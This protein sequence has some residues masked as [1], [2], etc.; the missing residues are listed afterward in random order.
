VNDDTRAVRERRIPDA[1]LATF[2]CVGML[3]M[4]TNPVSLA[5]LGDVLGPA[6]QFLGQ[7]FGAVARAVATTWGWVTPW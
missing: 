2:A 4:V 6:L 7:A 3:I 5:F 1:A